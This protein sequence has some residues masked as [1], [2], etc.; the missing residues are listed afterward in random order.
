METVI[1]RDTD[2]LREYLAALDA[3]ERELSPFARLVAAVK[4]AFLRGEINAA[5]L[6]TTGEDLAALRGEIRERLNRTAGRRMLSKPF[7][8]RLGVFLLLVLVQQIVL[9]GVLFAT[10]LFIHLVPPQKGWNPL[11]PNEQPGFLYAFIFCLFFVTPMLALLVLYGGRFFRSWRITLPATAALLGLSVAGTLLVARGRESSN[12]VKHLTSLQQFAKER[13]VSSLS[14][15]EWVDQNWLLNDAKFQR[16]YEAYFRN[17]PGRW[18]TSRL[19]STNDRAWQPRTDDKDSLLTMSEYLDDRRD[20]NGFRDWLRYYLDRNRIYSEERIDSEVSA[21]TGS[22]NQRYLGIWQVEPL[23]QERDKHLYRSY[24]GSINKATRQWLLVWLAVL[25]LAA[26]LVL[27]VSPLRSLLQDKRVTGRFRRQSATGNPRAESSDQT[28]SFPERSQ[29]AATPFFDTP[30]KLLARVHRSFLRLAVLTSI[31]VFIFWTAVY[32]MD[33][34]SG[35]NSAPSQISMMKSYMLFGG[36]SDSDINVDSVSAAN[37]KTGALPA[38]KDLSSSSDAERKGLLEK[39]IAELEQ[40]VDEAD[41]KNTRSF[42]LQYRTIESQRSELASLK[43][44][45]SQLQQTATSLPQQISAA[46]ARAGQG[47]G[48]ATAARETA[49]GVERNLS[50]RMKDLETR[51][52]R[53]SEQ[54][55]RVQDQASLLA[56]RTEALEKELDR[57][58]SQIEARTEEL[59]ERTTALNERE[60]RFARLQRLALSAI[61]AELRSSVDDIERRVDTSFYRLMG[62]SEAH[63]DADSL[64]QRIT[65]LVTELTAL[66]KDQFKDS[67]SELEELDKRLQQIAARIK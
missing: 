19:D 24:L 35:H 51:A 40:D 21:L 55:G 8:A 60:E 14:Y 10:W 29:I 18:I 16:D 9:L 36:R 12:P 43:S 49:E 66:G 20:P 45:A 15:R 56:T 25:I 7:R 38:G 46:D 33:L 30:F 67:I 61:L 37:V 42:R 52:T 27:I 44:E 11:L 17:G 32:S 3:H 5:Q 28:E 23:L 22:A 2:V 1:T 53:A 62:K 39:Q 57:R 6:E 50:T 58:A 47:I 13:D 26:L 48:E 34:A 41:Y 59:G 31:F 63:R 54:A 64:H 4:L 65:S